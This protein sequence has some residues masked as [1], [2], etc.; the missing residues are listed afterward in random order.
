MD[1]SEV[2]QTHHK[3]KVF[4]RGTS[5]PT[6]I[7]ADVPFSMEA[8]TKD[9]KNMVEKL[10]K[11][12]I[13]D[14]F[15]KFCDSESIPAV[16]FGRVVKAYVAMKAQKVHDEVMKQPHVAGRSR[17]GV[18]SDALKENTQP[19]LRATHQWPEC[20]ADWANGT[21]LRR[22]CVSVARRS[23]PSRRR[24]IWSTWTIPRAIGCSS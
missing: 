13:F 12:E 6:F 2:E 21:L 1:D 18:G 20:F 7:L 19:D 15:V 16:S 5:S 17:P 14:L 11:E 4:G 8:I 23:S 24:S 9:I 3:W 10:S 22:R